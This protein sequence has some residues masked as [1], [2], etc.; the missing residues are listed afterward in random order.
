RTELQ[1]GKKIRHAA[2][3]RPSRDRGSRGCRDDF[4]TKHRS[5]IEHALSVF[6]EKGGCQI[7]R[8]RCR[9]IPVFDGNSGHY[10][11]PLVLM[12]SSRTAPGVGVRMKLMELVFRIAIERLSRKTGVPARKA[13]GPSTAAPSTIMVMVT[14]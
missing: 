1:A 10:T 3:H 14:S 4:S 13:V 5:L 8:Q 12:K 11:A 2:N 6:T 7:P 9:A